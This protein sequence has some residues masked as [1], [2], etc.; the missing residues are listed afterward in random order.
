MGVRRAIDICLS[1]QLVEEDL[2]D[3]LLYIARLHQLGG[4]FMCSMLQDQCEK[5]FEWIMNNVWLNPYDLMPLGFQPKN[6]PRLML[7]ICAT[8]HEVVSGKGLRRYLPRPAEYFH[9]AFFAENPEWEKVCK[10]IHQEQARRAKELGCERNLNPKGQ[11]LRYGKQECDYRDNT[12]APRFMWTTKAARTKRKDTF[13]EWKLEEESVSDGWWSDWA[14][15][16]L[17]NGR[18]GMLGYMKGTKASECRRAKRVK[19]PETVKIE[20]A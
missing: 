11:Q 15:E 18:K 6:F 5:A 20:A 2:F 8:E 4:Y 14:M 16:A 9:E 19:S 17:K 10:I 12:K 13:V 1:D 7:E 3:P